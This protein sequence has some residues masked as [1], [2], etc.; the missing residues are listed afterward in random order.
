MPGNDPQMDV[1]VAYAM[2]DVA[3]VIPLQVT[4][5]S[6]IRDVIEQSSILQRC[7]E[8][9]LEQNKVGVFSNVR[10]LGDRVKNGDRVEI[11]RAL[12]VDPKEARRRRAE[13]QKTEK[14]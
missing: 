5:G 14:N 2:T 4:A 3:H 1:E 9:D 13:K 12:L 8:I 6:T 7:P 11:Y 10:D